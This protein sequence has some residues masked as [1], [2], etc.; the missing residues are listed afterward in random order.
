MCPTNILAHYEAF[1][2]VGRTIPLSLDLTYKVAL[3]RPMIGLE[4]APKKS[5]YG[6]VG[7]NLLSQDLTPLCSFVW[8]GGGVS[9]TQFGLDELG[10]V[11]KAV[12]C[13]I[14]AAALVGSATE[15]AESKTTGV[16]AVGSIFDFTGLD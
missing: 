12:V 2:G 6:I 9:H 11:T 1:W 5:D 15:C 16:V 3:P 10:L 13:K 14:V 7:V 4:P 8:I